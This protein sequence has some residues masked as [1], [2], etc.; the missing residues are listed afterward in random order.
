MNPPV[1]LGIETA[2]SVCG[3]AIADL[4]G[5]RGEALI[6]AGLSHSSRLMKLIRRVTSDVSIEVESLDALAV[7]IGPGSFTGIRIGMGAAL[8]LAAG[9]GVPLVGVPT[10]DA[11]A[12]SQRPFDG[13]VC[14]FIDARRG[15]VYFCLYEASGTD[16]K[17]MGEYSVLPPAGM[18]SAV[19]EALGRVGG[20]R[21]V[22]L[23]GPDSLLNA[24][25]VKLAGDE[26]MLTVSAGRSLPGPAA[27]ASMGVELYRKDKSVSPGSLRPIY[28][29]RSDAEL[30]RSRGR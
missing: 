11:L 14:P 1:V 6:D 16:I 21:R 9:A 17:R 27:V 3:A 5:P 10:L 18:V 12:W 30:K 13:I 20:D 2:T 23:A 28:V 22:L 25:G 7:S 24:A 8:G 19:A 4:D 15:E 29:R 26:R